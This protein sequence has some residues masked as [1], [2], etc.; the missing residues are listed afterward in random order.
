MM[1]RKLVA[2]LLATCT[3]VASLTGC[4][5]NEESAQKQSSS[6]T[7][8]VAEESTS[9]TKEEEKSIFNEEGYPIVNEEITLKVMQAVRETDNVI[10]PDD[11][12]SIQKLEELTGINLEWEV[13]KTNDWDTKLNLMF[14]SGEYA[15]IILGTHGVVDIKNMVYQKELLFPWMN[16]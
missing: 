10:D 15:D 2:V 4:G 7:Q 14:A 1:K 5:S 12:P 6:Q 8:E 16:S 11:M 3:M 9:V 13:V